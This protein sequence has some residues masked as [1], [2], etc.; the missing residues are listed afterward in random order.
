MASRVVGLIRETIFARFFGAGFLYDAFIVGFRIPNLLRDLFAEGAMSAAFVPTFTRLLTLHGR[1]RAW[2][3]ASSVINGLL[4]VTGIVMSIAAA[5]I[6][7]TSMEVNSAARQVG[8]TLLA[9]TLS[10]LYLNSRPPAGAQQVVA[11]F[12]NAFPLLEGM[13]VRVGG[14]IAGSVGTI[15][16]SDEGLARVTLVLDDSVA[17]ATADASAA[18]RQQDTT[19]DSYVSFEPGE[20]G[21]GLPEVD[22]KATIVCGSPARRRSIAPMR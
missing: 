21:E 6:D 18:I 14:A 8:A 3:L 9:A 17:E 10:F 7:W 20:A 13:H 11:E 2:Q 4:L 16:V 22:G 19:G 5:R 15:E 1:E 12:R